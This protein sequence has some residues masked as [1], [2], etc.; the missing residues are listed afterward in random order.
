MPANEK[1]KPM[2]D[3]AGSSEGHKE[4][5]S[6]QEQAK[7]IPEYLFCWQ[8]LHR[9]QIRCRL[10]GD[11]HGH[12]STFS[13]GCSKLCTT[14]R[15]ETAL[16]PRCESTDCLSTDRPCFSKDNRV[17]YHQFRSIILFGAKDAAGTSSQFHSLSQ[18]GSLC[19]DCQGCYQ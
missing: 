1:N 13:A 14:P 18:H 7:N 8:W 15:A 3:P 11:W 19:T 5:L 12:R 10:F 4:I 6:E 16:Q 2:K 9:L 17:F